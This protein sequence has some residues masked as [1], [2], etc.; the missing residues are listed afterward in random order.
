MGKEGRWKVWIVRFEDNFVRDGGP[1][2]RLQ[3]VKITIQS[4]YQR[5]Y[6]SMNFYC[7]SVRRYVVPLLVRGFAT[8]RE[9]AGG[10]I[11]I[12]RGSGCNFL[13]VLG[14]VNEIY[15]SIHQGCFGARYLLICWR[16]T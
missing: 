7:S 15:N 8:A 14:Y 1:M 2:T 9:R 5:K 13:L 10:G 3:D 12:M 11:A 16:R 4:A 6:G